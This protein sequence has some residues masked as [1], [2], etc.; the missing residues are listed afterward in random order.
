MNLYW[1]EM[2]KLLEQFSV[3]LPCS[4]TTFSMS[5]PPPPGLL[6]EHYDVMIEQ[7]DKTIDE[8]VENVETGRI[9]D[10][11]NDRDKGRKIPPSELTRVT[12]THESNTLF[13]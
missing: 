10:S 13:R 4:Q 1:A 9:R 2:A 5:S 8:V 7:L 6:T 11:E 12:T 3:D